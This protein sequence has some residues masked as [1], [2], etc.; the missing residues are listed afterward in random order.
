MTKFITKFLLIILFISGVLYWFDVLSFADKFIPLNFKKLSSQTTT[1]QTT[2]QNTNTSTANDIT[3]PA[4]PD[5][6][7]AIAF[8]QKI[9]IQK[10]KELASQPFQNPEN[11]LPEELKKLDYDKHKN[12]RWERKNNPWANKRLPFELTFHHLGSIFQIP[13]PIHE[14]YRGKALPLKYAPEMFTYN[15]IPLP[16]ENA[17]FSNWVKKFSTDNPPNTLTGFAGFRL[18]T[19]LNTKTYYDDLISFLGASYFRALS[20]K[21]HYGIS[22]RGLAIDTAEQTGEEFPYF[23]EFWIERPNPAETSVKVYALLDSPSISGAYKFTI[24]PAHLTPSKNTLV[25]VEANLFPRTKIKKLGIAP[26]TSMFLF[27]ENTKNR[28]DDYRPEVHDS[29]GLLILNGKGEWLWR[30]LDNSKY[31]RISSFLDETPQGFGLLQRDR[32]GKHYYDLENEYEKRP[33]VWVEPLGN[34]GKGMLQLV[35]IPSIK[36]VND[37]IVTYWVPEAEIVPEQE[38]S[39]KYML[40]WCDNIP[41]KS[42]VARVDSTLTGTDS[43]SSLLEREKRKFVVNFSGK[44][45]ETELKEQLIKPDVYLSEGEILDVSLVYNPLT[46]GATVYFDFVPPRKIS[47]IRIA[48]KKEDKIISEVWSYQWLP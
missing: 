17:I 7:N 21:Q 1:N 45:S 46:K 47:E 13:V 43:I 2:Q 35:E 18:H 40:Y 16:E 4:E 11:I 22:A 30:P 10:A 14:V 41:K 33:S 5:P 32:R 38:Y 37:N 23:K 28:F 36:D 42:N 29:D 15:H 12:L 27:G 44:F 20:K 9:L 19:Q 31:L 34:W 6:P 8:N 25:E 39:F 26:L 24:T 3:E 48:L